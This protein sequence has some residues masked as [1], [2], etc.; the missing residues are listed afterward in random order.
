MKGISIPERTEDFTADPVELFFDLAYVIA[1]SQLVGVLIHEPTW[2]GF[3][4]VALV[5][6]LLWLPWQ[7]LTWTANAISG[8]GR[9]VRAIF[10]IATA[11]SVPMA[12]STSTALAGGGVA[13]AVTLTSI[14][15]L[16][17]AMQSL[18]AA[19]GTGFRRA[20]VRWIAPNV[21][22][23]VVLLVGATTDGPDRIV[24][25]SVSLVVVLGAMVAAGNGEWVI[26]AGHFAERHALIVIIALGEVIV[27]IGLPVQ[28]A[29]E[30]QQG[31]PGRTIA[32]LV[33]SG[34]FAALIW[35]GYFDRPGPALEHTANSIE[36]HARGRYVRDVYTW[37][38]A[39]IVIGIVLSAAALEAITLHP[40]DSLDLPFRLML[41]G[42]FGLLT[43]GIG[44]A[45]WRAFGV[46]PKERLVCGAALAVPVLTW[47]GD[48][49]A[50]L[51]LVDTVVF[52]TLLV[53]HR[54]VERS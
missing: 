28:A 6:G 35:W 37:C 48:G 9:G 2:P 10:L 11:V 34:T 43:L 39:P 20:V 23:V 36:E 44:V 40:T 17:F 30:T 32:A 27:A 21:V 24:L 42:G 25:W 38:H 53:E 26:R 7:Q 3:G 12:A 13:F 8:N 49:I 1:F 31:L 19:R 47:T 22:A 18:S 41:L 29:L 51:V 50:L 14:M 45:I 33:G 54:A 52:V 46:W 15:A 5:F 16:G 4:K